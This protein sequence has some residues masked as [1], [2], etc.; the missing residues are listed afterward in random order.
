MDFQYR[1]DSLINILPQD[2]S[3]IQLMNDKINKIF[4][5]LPNLKKLNKVNFSRSFDMNLL[6]SNYQQYKDTAEK[7][8]ILSQYDL[9]K[10]DLKEVDIQKVINSKQK[11]MVI[12][13]K[14]LQC[15]VN[16]LIVVEKWIISTNEQ[17]EYLASVTEEI[18]RFQR[19]I[20]K[21]EY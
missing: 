9:D 10:I 18:K 8:M 19:S 4:L 3:D 14:Y 7:L 5:D 16:S 13:S 1:I 2:V 21:N 17:N 20:E 6:L 15:L 12:V 11:I